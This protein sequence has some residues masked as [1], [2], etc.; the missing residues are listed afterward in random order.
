[1]RALT[2]NNPS[3]TLEEADRQDEL[4]STTASIKYNYGCWGGDSVDAAEDSGPGTDLNGA[5]LPEFGYGYGNWSGNC[6]C[7]RSGCGGCGG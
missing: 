4:A 1:M 2:L 7:G 6:G 5:I 3:W